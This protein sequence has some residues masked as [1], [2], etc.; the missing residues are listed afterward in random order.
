M[1]QRRNAVCGFSVSIQ[2][3]RDKKTLFS[4][5][6]YRFETLVLTLHHIN[7]FCQLE[8]QGPAPTL[9]LDAC[10]SGC[11]A[12]VSVGF[13]VLHRVEVLGSSGFQKAL[14]AQLVRFLLGLGG[15]QSKEY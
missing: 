14:V 11:Q 15:G 9:D 12:P 13:E 8:E 1:H 4:Y 10:L 2:Y 7:R 6:C 3:T 5:C